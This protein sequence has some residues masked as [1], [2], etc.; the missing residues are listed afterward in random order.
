MSVT[1]LF[2]RN[3]IYYFRLRLPKSLTSRFNCKEIKFSLRTSDKNLARIKNYKI[4]LVVLK[5]LRQACENETIG[6][7]DLKNLKARV[8]T[9]ST[10]TTADGHSIS[11]DMPEDR[12]KEHEAL[13]KAVQMH[14]EII[15]KYGGS[16][17]SS[18]PISP[19]ELTHPTVQAQKNSNQLTI[20]EAFNKLKKAKT[21]QRTKKWKSATILDYQDTHQLYLEHI[22]ED[23][24]LAEI[25]VNEHLDFKNTLLN[26]PS[27]RS[28]KAEYRDLSID[29]LLDMDIPESHLMSL[30]TINNHITRINTL[31]NWLKEERLGDLPSIKKLEANAEISAREAR[32]VYTPD[33]FRQIFNHSNYVNNKFKEDYYYWLIPLAMYTGGRLRE[34]CQLETGDIRQ[35]PETKIWFIDINTKLSEELQD[36]GVVKSLKTAASKRQI[37]IHSHLIE[38][39]FLD[40]V[41]FRRISYYSIFLFNLKPNAQGDISVAASKW[42]QRYRKTLDLDT[43][44][45]R[46]DFH[47]LRHTFIDQLFNEDVAETVNKDIV[48]HSH[49][50]V[51]TKVYRKVAKL[52]KLKDGLE[53]LCYR[54]CMSKIKP[55]KEVSPNKY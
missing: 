44:D 32:A 41:N 15:Q 24:Q 3:G 51:T 16:H 22:G 53:T 36:T 9:L 40:F 27:N 33:E 50:S 8:C 47:S 11:V 38:L 28:K 42:F 26:L 2:N 48:G 18:N 55:W 25:R 19:P 52:R 13:N 10:Y 45:G 29:E 1:Y 31:V 34:L 30:S 23:K 4:S 14:Y 35:C 39:G 21:D 37:P 46:K 43:S 20:T 5:F 54:D 17:I 49:T 12:E 6:M 7:I